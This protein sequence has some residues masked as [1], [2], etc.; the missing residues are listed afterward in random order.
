MRSLPETEAVL[1]ALVFAE[2]PPSELEE[3]LDALSVA[4][5]AAARKLASSGVAMPDLLDAVENLPD[6]SACVVRWVQDVLRG[7]APAADVIDL[8]ETIDRVHGQPELFA[9]RVRTAKAATPIDAAAILDETGSREAFERL[10]EAHLAGRGITPFAGAGMS[11]ESG[12]PGWRGFLLEQA[13]RFR[14]SAE[15][16]ALLDRGE[17]EQAAQLLREA[18]ETAQFTAL[19]ETTYGADIEPRGAVLLLPRITAGPVITTNYDG[20]I[21]ASYARAGIRLKTVIGAF[22]DQFIEALHAEESRTLLKVHGDA[23]E[24]THRV[25]TADEYRQ[26]YEA[27]SARLP[28]LLRAAFVSRQTLFLGCSFADQR[29]IDAL[30]GVNAQMPR[31]FAIMAADG[32]EAKRRLLSSLGIEVIA[33]RHRQYADVRVLLD[34]FA[35][36]IGART[37]LTKHVKKALH[38]LAESLERPLHHIRNLATSASR[39]GASPAMRRAEAASADRSVIALV[40]TAQQELLRCRKLVSKE[41]APGALLALF[42][43]ADQSLG[44]LAVSRGPD[45]LNDATRATKQLRGAINALG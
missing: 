8:A 36:A 13:K 19:L 16:E 30:R 4:L 39:A 26:E 43:A 24:R 14:V 31:H 29:L 27:A 37:R 18:A 1:R 23:K 44:V 5:D 6:R 40:K 32:D 41:G 10:V 45:Q 17:Y 3:N 11:A 2:A 28:R 34:A 25:L 21:E 12:F 38:D 15:I 35:R 33:Y 22:E 7:R 20:M 42:D 9:R